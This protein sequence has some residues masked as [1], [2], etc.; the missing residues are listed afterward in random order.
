[1]F[2]ACSITDSVAKNA[3]VVMGVGV[4]GKGLQKSNFLHVC[5][6]VC[7]SLFL[8]IALCKYMQLV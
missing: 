8:S 1:M 6:P 5:L 4:L 2:V 7:P 3:V